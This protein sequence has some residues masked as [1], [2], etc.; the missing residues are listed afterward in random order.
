MIFFKIFLIYVVINIVFYLISLRK[1]EI[2][3]INT[4]ALEFKK[5]SNLKFIL[6][7]CLVIAITITTFL[8]GFILNFF[9]R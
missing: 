6:F 4:A 2:Q 9:R 7:H 1:E 3:E 8:P 5:E